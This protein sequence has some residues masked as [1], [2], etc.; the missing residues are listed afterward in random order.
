M[1][2]FGVKLKDDRHRPSGFRSGELQ[3]IKPNRILNQQ[4]SFAGNIDAGFHSGSQSRLLNQIIE[5][6][7]DKKGEEVISLDLRAIPEAVADYFVICEADNPNQ[8]R[9]IADSVQHRVR[10]YCQEIPYHTEGYHNGG[11][12][13]IDYVNVVVHVMHRDTRSF[14]RLEEMWSDAPMQEHH[15]A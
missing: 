6:I 2:N 9:A 13:L 8:L 12:I 10:Q 1:A 11:W 5:G 3:F 14:Y 4:A 7:F 15:P